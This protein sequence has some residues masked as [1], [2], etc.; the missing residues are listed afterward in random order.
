MRTTRPLSATILL[1]GLCACEPVQPRGPF[2]PAPAGPAVT[3]AAP[4][5]A[6]TGSATGG[7][8]FEAEDRKDDEPTAPDGEVDPLALQAGVLGIDPAEVEP[9]PPAPAPAPAP[10]AQAP[11]PAAPAPLWLPD[12]PLDGGWGLRV[13]ATLLD[14]QPPRAVIATADGQELVVQPGQMLPEHRLVVLAV[15][16]GAVQ[17]ARVTP[18]GFYARVETETV[19]ALG[20]P[21]SG[22][23]AP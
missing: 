12:Q 13:I 10:V 19:P 20:A 6:S 4:A 5:S 15:G 11:A 9:P 21:V 8:D 18:Q 17:V 16:R 23:A 2:V 22:V 3:A 14:V 1:F 7:F